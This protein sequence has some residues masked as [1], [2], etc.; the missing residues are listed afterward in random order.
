MTETTPDPALDYLRKMH[1]A[2]EGTTD[3]A[4]RRA[5]RVLRATIVM[6]DLEGERLNLNGVQAVSALAIELLEEIG[7]KLP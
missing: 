2:R 7:H 6:L 4:W 3:E 1:D 5:D